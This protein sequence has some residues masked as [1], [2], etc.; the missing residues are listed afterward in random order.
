MIELPTNDLLGLGLFFGYF[1]VVGLP[2]IILKVRLN[3]PSELFRKMLHLLITMSI[4]PLVKL[5]STW[6]MA[7]FAAF[8]LVLV[9]Y[10]VLALVERSS[11]YKQVAVERE[12]GE[13]KRSLVIVQL[14][15]ATLIAVFWGFLGIDWHYV[16]IVAVMAWGFGDAAAALVGKAYGRHQIEHPH[17]EGKKT[18][19]G[20]LAMYIVAGLAIFFTLLV[21]AGQSWQMSLGIASLVAPV[22]ATVELFSRRGLDTL[23]VPMAVAFLVMPLTLLFESLGV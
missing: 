11:L 8:M 18:Y 7:V 1:I 4:F 22:S 15:L 2:L 10:P 5:F 19:E 13:F 14:S 23:T 9:M 20:T 6:V 3:A 16:A 17:I 21:Y 12:G